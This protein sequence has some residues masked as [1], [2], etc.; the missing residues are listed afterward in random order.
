MKKGDR[1]ER[2]EI[3]D[4]SADGKSVGRHE[5]MVVFVNQAVPGDVVTAQVT[6]TR[7]KHVEAN[8]VAILEP[9]EKRA[10]PFCKHFGL[11]GGCKWQHLN[12]EAQLTYKQRHVAHNLTKLSGIELP[13]IQP[14]LGSVDTRYYRN[15]LEFTFSNKRWLTKNEINHA[16]PVNRDG[17]GFHIPRMFDKILD[18]E[19]CHLQ[20]EPSNRIRLAVSAYA[21]A[22]GLPFFD[23]RAQFGLMRN[24]I[25]RTTTTGQ[26]MVI[27]QFFRKDEA[28]AGLLDHLVEEFPEITSLQ[29]VINPKKNETF[30]DLPIQ[31]YKGPNYIEEKMADLTF[32]I[33]PKS[34]YQTNSKQ[35]EQLYA[36]V[37]QLAG[38]EGHERVYDLYT[39]TGTIANYLAREVKEVIGIEYVPEAVADARINSSING[40]K[41]TRFFA[42]DMRDLM[43]ADFVAQ[44]GTPD[45]VVLDPPRAGMHPDVVKALNEL[46]VKQI[47][48]ISCNPATQARDLETLAQVYD[49]QHIQPVDMFPQTQH[50]ENVMK[51]TLRDGK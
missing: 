33:G 35:A 22:H 16:E 9:S 24:L 43:T 47:I 20:A 42:G 28:I 45:V 6:Y 41:N 34:F 5:G 12:Y 15:K 18:L 49:V 29:Y 3:T 10:E 27:V 7:R 30:N 31:V 40:I 44:H 48:Y 14:I 37:K 38:F 26:T 50:V 19:E 2:L 1:L 17:L 21:K 13:P 46:A 51:L 4:I 32:R 11:C 36:L 8:V 23:I 25:V 39:G